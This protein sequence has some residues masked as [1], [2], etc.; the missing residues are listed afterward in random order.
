MK[1]SQ[2]II[3]SHNINTVLFVIKLA[4]PELFTTKVKALCKIE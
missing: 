1:L 3:A 2:T 4:L